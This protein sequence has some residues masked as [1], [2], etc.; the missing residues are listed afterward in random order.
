MSADEQ[1]GPGRVAGRQFFFNPG[2]THIPDSV[3]GAMHRPVI[4]FLAPE[5]IEVLTRVHERTKRV[6]KCSQHLLFY[7]TGGK[8]WLNKLR[9][10]CVGLR[11]RSTLRF[12]LHTTSVC[13]L[14]SVTAIET[15]LWFWD[16][17]S[18]TCSL[19]S[20]EPISEAQADFLKDQ[21]K[22]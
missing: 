13:N 14:D 10:P 20:F 15:R 19:G 11:P 8:V 4:D 1:S 5:F 18:A 17:A 2:P 12:D 3:F 9:T 16:R 6:L 7:G 21:L 22:R